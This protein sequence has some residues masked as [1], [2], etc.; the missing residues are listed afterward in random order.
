MVPAGILD[1]LEDVK[2]QLFDEHGL[3]FWQ[4]ILDGL[5]KPSGKVDKV[6]C[7]TY[8]LNHSTAVH[9]KR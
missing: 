8:F 1:T 3:L 9:L 2:F 6:P 5:S 4:N 7:N